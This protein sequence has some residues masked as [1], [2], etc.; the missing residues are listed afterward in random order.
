MDNIFGF[1]FKPEGKCSKGNRGCTRHG[2]Y[3]VVFQQSPERETM[4]FL[5]SLVRLLKPKN[6]LEVGAKKGFVTCY[7]A[8]AVRKNSVG[9]VTSFEGNKDYAKQAERLIKSFDFDNVVTLLTEDVSRF[10]V[11]K[12]GRR[13]DFCFIDHEDAIDI[14][15]K[16]RKAGAIDGSTV[17]VLHDIVPNLPE[18]ISRKYKKALRE[19]L[20]KESFDFLGTPR[21]LAII[22]MANGKR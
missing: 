6:I 18:S 20:L 14:L 17:V 4:E 15:Y 7:L 3:E 22:R 5:Y 21:G 13:Y 16:L 2:F 8:K 9:L 1:R 19:G 11:F 10:K 12:L